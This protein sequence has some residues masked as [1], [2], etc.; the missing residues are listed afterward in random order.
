MFRFCLQWIILEWQASIGECDTLLRP[1]NALVRQRKGV[2]EMWL[3]SW[4]FYPGFFGIVLG[5][6]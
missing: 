6:I 1:S 4:D 2:D 3:L 5:S